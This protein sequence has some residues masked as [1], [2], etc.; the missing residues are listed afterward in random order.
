MY[1]GGV[2]SSGVTFIT[3]FV[4]ID[5]VDKKLKCGNIHTHA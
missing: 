2:A 3:N 1:D 4:K 5:R